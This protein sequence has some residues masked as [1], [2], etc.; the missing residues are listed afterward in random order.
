MRNFVKFVVS[1]ALSLYNGYDA[2]AW[3]ALDAENRGN[4]R[5]RPERTA[6]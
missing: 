6:R 2:N 4:L 5:W 1:R 3:G